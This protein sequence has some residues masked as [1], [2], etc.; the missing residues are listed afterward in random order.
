[1]AWKLEGTYFENCSC[2]FSC[3]CT[4][5]FDAGADYDRCRVL[6]AF[7]VGSGTV[8][9]VDV[10]GLGAALVADTP[11][12]MSEG[13]WRVGLVLDEAASD[14]QAE[15]LGAVFAGQL[16]GPPGLLAALLGEMLGVE[17]APFDWSEN[18]LDHRVR[19]GDAVEIGVEDVVPF[20]SQT[21]Q[22]AQVTG[23]THPANS[24]LT[25]ARGKGSSGSVFGVDLGNDGK[26]AFSAPFSWAG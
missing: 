13:N 3:P 9:G 23:V 14:E 1:M 7:H 19:I 10:S 24:T 17:R 18:G 15:K 26:S 12:V 16:G 20:G 6:L 2:D 4:L 11:K 21:G 5:S 25:V 8:D 22:P